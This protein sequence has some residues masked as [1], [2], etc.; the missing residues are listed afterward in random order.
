MPS[1]GR[2]LI[3]GVHAELQRQRALPNRVVRVDR[4]L[5]IRYV[6]ED[7][8]GASGIEPAF[9]LTPI[10]PGAPDRRVL[11][12]TLA[13]ETIEQDAAG[14]IWVDD[15][16]LLPT[17]L[18]SFGGAESCREFA[19]QIGECAA[20]LLIERQRDGWDLRVRVTT[21]ILW[22]HGLPRPIADGPVLDGWL[23]MAARALESPLVGASRS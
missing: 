10:A 7:E 5:G 20:L 22:I 15:Q 4:Y 14:A 11:F 18:V 12:E 9:W 1:I 8:L 13:N 23:T 19:L 21:P 17:P 2:V 16:L 3:A 6:S